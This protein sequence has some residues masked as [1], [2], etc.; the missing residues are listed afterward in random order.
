MSA[1]VPYEVVARLLELACSESGFVAGPRVQQCVYALGGKL[2]QRYSKAALEQRL[3]A[4]DPELLAEL[5]QAIS[6]G[7]TF[8]FRQPEHFDFLREEI[9]RRFAGR[10]AIN[11]WSAGCSTGEEAF[12]VAAVL[13]AAL[14]DAAVSVLGTDLDRSRLVRAQQGVI[15]H[16]AVREGSSIDVPLLGKPVQGGYEVLPQ[17][18]RLVRFERHNLLEAAPGAFDVVLCRNVLIYFTD[19]AVN[20]ACARLAQGLAPGGMLM[21]GAVEVSSTP[22]GLRRIGPAELQAFERAGGDRPAATPRATPPPA[23]PKPAAAKAPAP[24]KPR[25]PP[26]PQVVL[27][28]SAIA[29]RD[30]ADLRGS[31]D[32]LD[33]LC[34]RYPNYLP[35]LLDRALLHARLGERSRAETVMRRLAEL[36]RAWPSGRQ[37]EGPELLGAEYYLESASAWLARPRGAR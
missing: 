22:P 11:A 24:A 8:V 25:L 35:G 37:V 17:V 3:D 27:H 21:L 14:P 36:A 9:T 30:G 34:S 12:T 16:H 19:E 15:R 7:E 28:L 10:S 31:A 23:A 33:E 2:T 5:H 18:R 13:Q 29:R 4:K 32:L 20:A 26:A 6:V 1:K